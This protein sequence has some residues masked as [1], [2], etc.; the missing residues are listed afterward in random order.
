M[1]KKLAIGL[2]VSLAHSI[3]LC[4]A[5]AATISPVSGEV[6]VNKGDGF[7][8]ISSGA[9]LAPGGQLMV[10]PGGVAVISYA[11]GCTVQVGAGRI[12]VVQDNP[13][14]TEGNR[15]IDF[16]GRMN[17]GSL[18]DSPVV[19]EERRYD[20]GPIIWA[21]VLAGGITAIV[22][23]VTHDHDHDHGRPISP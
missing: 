22:I 6:L 3:G 14:C 15:S 21:G 19:E 16:T 2:A 23:G 8:A 20:L 10:R 13:P 5:D 4:A 11:S 17:G 18:K 9:E 12:W 1:I 7:V